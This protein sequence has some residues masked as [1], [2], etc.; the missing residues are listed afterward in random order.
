MEQAFPYYL[1]IGM[2][3]EQYWNAD[4]YLARDYRQAHKLR[5]EIRNQELWMQGMYFY[6]AVQT[7]VYNVFRD[8]G[9]QAEKYVE[10][11]YE[12]YPKKTNDVEKERLKIVEYLN[13]MKKNFDERGKINVGHD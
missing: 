6:N 8:K 5:N 9:K 13:R 4:P 3:Y 2:S 10:K 11:P 12:L 1:A 7:A